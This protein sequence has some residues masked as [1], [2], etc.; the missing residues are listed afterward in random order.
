MAKIIIKKRVNLS[1]LGEEHKDDYLVF[2]SIP[3]K[4]FRKLID[5]KPDDSNG[6]QVDFI[7]DILKDRFI[8]GKFLGEDVTK[9]DIG[10]FDAESIVTCFGRLTGQDPDP[11]V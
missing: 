1:F 3:V 10:D 2:S 8:E 5:S 7:V 9:E 4:E 11:K 6:G